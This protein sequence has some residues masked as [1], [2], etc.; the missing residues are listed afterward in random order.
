[1]RW[2]VVLML[3]LAIR[4][5]AC[6][7]SGNWASAK[8]A[9]EK[10][11]FVFLGTVETADPDA[12][13]QQTI[14]QEQSVRI[15]VDD[16]FKGV[17]AG[18]TIELHQGADDCSAKF[19][20]GQRA[21]F[22]L[23]KGTQGWDVPPC[24]RSLGSAAARGDDLLFLR[25]LPAS[26]KGTR[27]SGE[28]ELYEDSPKEASHR[29]RGLPGVRVTISGPLGSRTE[30]VTNADG[31]Y[32]LYGLPPGKYS[33]RI[34]VP[35]GLRLT[36]PV[37][38]GSAPV[39]GDESAVELEANGG[40]SVGFVLKADTRLTGRVLGP[41]GNPITGIC[42]DLDPVEGRGE[43]GARFFDCSKSGGGFAM[44]MMP[45]GQ[46]RLAA[47][48]EVKLDDHKSK[49][50]LYY[51]DVRDRDRAAI[52]SIEAGK[53]VE[54]LDIRVPSD[55]KRNRITGRMQFE[56]GAPVPGAA[57]TFNSAQHGY[58]E[59]TQT[60]AEGSFGFLVVAGME[61]ELQGVMAVMTPILK[62]CPELKVGPRVRGMLRFMDAN[63]I[64][65]SGD[66]NHENLKLTL[67]SPSCKA[68]P[69]GK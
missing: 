9:W 1:M 33:A 65:L 35:Q 23:Y 46:Y 34:R 56:D 10:A 61:G 29:V 12:D 4:A 48:D 64:P 68:W 31:A 62:S 6:S 13:P 14:F 58:T 53:Y 57:V 66:S 42:I 28:V 59:T 38:V 47:H 55:E 20:T 16:P 67:P 45:P 18:Q 41:R 63:P 17:F 52:V 40:V 24:S 21:V 43:N 11:P 26:A 49:S 51:P 2:L 54:H 32:E 5:E 22:Y 7:Y 27:L 44:E 36:F 39:R 25:G 60:D 37:V 19:R 15:R 8:Q 50:T 30:T 69:P 3:M